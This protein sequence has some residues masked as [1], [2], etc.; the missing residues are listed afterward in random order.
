MLD[1]ERLMHGEVW[2]LIT[3]QLIYRNKAQA[4]VGLILLY[5]TRQFER[6]MGVKKFGAFMIFSLLISS[7]TM[8]AFIVICLTIGIHFVPSSGPFFL[9]YALMAFYY[10]KYLMIFLY[11]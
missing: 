6:Q 1:L 10:C 5:S 8:M 4:I 11:F 7:L 9:I 2:R 3:S